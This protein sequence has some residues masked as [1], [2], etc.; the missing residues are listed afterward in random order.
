MTK[1]RI[2]IIAVVVAAGV[3]L[4]KAGREVVGLCP[5][6]VEK[7]PSFAVNA[8]KNLWYCHGCHEGG[9]AIAFVMKLYGFGFKDAIKH[10][11][12]DGGEYK[13][14]PVDS[15]KRHA[16]T[17]LAGWLNQQHLLLGARLREL[18]QQIN[19]A[20]QIPNSELV[21][22]LN[23]E[24]EILADL[25]EDLAQPDCA[26]ALWLARATIEMLTAEIEPEPVDHFQPTVSS[27]S[28]LNSQPVESVTI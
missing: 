13:P 19:I 7:T 11:R 3:E 15:R 24:W 14:K 12:I 9:D 21:E 2:N 6:H 4:R 1:P 18:S 5:F 23:R 26:E 25:H 28:S 17:L 10:L 16:A 8:D 20:E 22:A 27:P